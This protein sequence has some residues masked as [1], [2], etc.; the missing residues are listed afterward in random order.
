M[1]SDIVTLGSYCG[2]NGCQRITITHK[3]G[4]DMLVTHVLVNNQEP[5]VGIAMLNKPVSVG[6]DALN[7]PIG[8]TINPKDNDGLRIGISL[9]CKTSQ[10]EWEYLLVNEG[11]IL[12]IDGECVMV[13]RR[14][15]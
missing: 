6:V 14:K 2:I 5:E 4:G 10:G 7:P 13:K 9:V 3:G 11:R 15:S 1:H 12:L 8:V